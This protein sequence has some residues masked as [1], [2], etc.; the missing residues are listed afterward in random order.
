MAIS[1]GGEM[2][3]YRGEIAEALGVKEEDVICENCP[4]SREFLSDTLI[5]DF[6]DL[7]TP[8]DGFCPFWGKEEK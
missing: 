4:S 2:N 8:R 5:C 1:K 7:C 6:H 3:T